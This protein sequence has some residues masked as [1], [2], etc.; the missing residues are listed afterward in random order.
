MKDPLRQEQFLDVIDRDEAERRFR[1]ALDLRPLEGETVPLSGALGRVLARDVVAPLDVPAFDRS[2][3][4]GF[5]V[6]AA[7][8]FGAAEDRPKTLQINGEVIATGFAPREAVRSGT[9]SGIATGGM[10]PRGADAVVMVEHTDVRD[11]RL[12]LVRPV[13]P[14]ANLSFAGTDI[15]QGEVVL[16]RGERL[17]SR[18]TGV[19]AALGLDSVEVVRR[20]RV[21]ILST[22]DELLPPGAAMRP[23]MVHDSNSTVLADAVRELGGEPI[24]LGIVPDDDA[25]LDEALRR[26]LVYDA[27]LLSGGTSKGA[28]DLSYRAV[29]RLGKPGIV[30][31]GVALKPGK[32]LCLAVVHPPGRRPIP[33]A[34]LPGFPTSAIFTFHE[35]LAPVLRLLAGQREQRA[36]VV[37][38]RL[39]MRVTSERGRTEYLLVGLIPTEGDKVTR[40]QGDKVTDDKE[41]ASVTLSPGHLVTLSP[42]LAAYPMGKGSGSVTAFSRADGFIV[43]GRQRE[44]LERDSEVEVHLL[45]SDLRPADLVVIGSHCTGLDFLIGLLNERGFTSKVMA[46]GSTGGLEAA[47]RGECDLAGV[48]LLD[49]STE[50]YNRPF[51][52]EALDLVPG[53]GRRQGVVFRSGDPRFEGKPLAE[54]V[55]AALADPECVLVN[56]NRGSGTRLLIDRLLGQARPLGYLA[57]ARSHNAVAAAV[58]Q[59]RADWGVA[60]DIVA[61]SSSLG[62]IPL[63]AEQYD[64]VVPKARRRRAAVEAFVCLLHEPATR[65]ALAE[66]GFS[67]A[68]LDRGSQAG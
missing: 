59:G 26:A 7:D 42:S 67:P 31:H 68:P 13:A 33:A 41:A 2:N 34:V 4:D 15:G 30:A 32:P 24:P 36:D 23:G 21:A 19:V 16:R 9:A 38:A 58:A 53:Y 60:I 62:F 47:K 44:Y 40:W 39:P 48:H 1:A 51:L 22:G 64:F 43:I 20:P 18:E 46:V 49:P 10:L 54:A 50:V 28:G 5:A 35:F 25:R 52:T 56:R 55:A 65:Q 14:G 29:A 37:R 11:G 45:A 63:R 17:T 3:V 61:R 66:M 12:V 57:E 27:I 8:T 6:Q